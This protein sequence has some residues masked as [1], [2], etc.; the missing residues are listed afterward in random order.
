MQLQRKLMSRVTGAR[1]DQKDCVCV[2]CAHTKTHT[3]EYVTAL[4]VCTH[5]SKTAHSH[6]HT[7][8]PVRVMGV[9]TVVCFHNP[10]LFCMPVRTRT[11]CTVTVPTHM[12]AHF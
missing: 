8:F 9:V 11:T 4:Q 7:H 12:R 6:T 3:H 2:C 1:T 10:S 5:E